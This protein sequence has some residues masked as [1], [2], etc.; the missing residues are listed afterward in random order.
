MSCF[1]NLWTGPNRQYSQKSAGTRKSCLKRLILTFAQWL[2]HLTNQWS[3]NL[4]LLI[5]TNQLFLKTIYLI[6][7]S[8]PIKTLSPSP[9]IRTLFGFPHKS[10]YSELQFFYPKFFLWTGF[11]IL[12]W[13]FISMIFFYICAHSYN[14]HPHQDIQHFWKVST[15]NPILLLIIPF[16]TLTEVQELS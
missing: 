4:V 9:R 6:F 7:L 12:G 11:L 5:S 8:S 1:L 14:H 16:L 15:L 3:T 2:L 10:V 13:H